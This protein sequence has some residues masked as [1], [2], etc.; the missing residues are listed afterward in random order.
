MASTY[1]IKLYHEILHDPKM[2][3]LPDK[4][5]RRFIELCLLAGEYDQDGVLPPLEDIAWTLRLDDAE[6]QS[7]LDALLACGMVMA[8]D[9][10]LVVTNFS[11]RQA[12]IPGAERVARY[13][14]R[15]RKEHYYCNESLQDTAAIR[16]ADTDTD[17][18]TD[19]DQET[20]NRQ[21]TGAP[22]PD[23]AAVVAVLSEFGFAVPEVIARETRLPPDAVRSWCEDGLQKAQ[24]LKNWQGY[25][26]S[27]LRKNVVPPPRAGPDRLRYING[28]FGD[29]V[30]H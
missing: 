16:Y 6:L 21:E 3:R 7:D 30:E 25:V 26:R 29:Y 12:A 17:T 4:L 1:W 13:R 10:L 14:E 11:K 22:A 2:G 23:V 20:D 9:G 27:Q 8:D 5:W 15:Q 19:T 18:D 24:K 28:E